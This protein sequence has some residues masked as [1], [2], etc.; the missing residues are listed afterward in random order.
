MRMMPPSLSRIGRSDPIDLLGM[1]VPVS[2]GT[3]D[4]GE[5]SLAA[6]IEH[7]LHGGRV[8]TR[9]RVEDAHQLVLGRIGELHLEQEAIELGFGQSKFRFAAPDKG[10]DGREWK[11]DDRHTV[12]NR[13][14]M[15]DAISRQ[16]PRW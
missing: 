9:R 5:R 16:R 7:R 12:E 11:L 1:L 10:I 3:R 13:A 6:R 15:L 2:N 14:S 8:G 4:P